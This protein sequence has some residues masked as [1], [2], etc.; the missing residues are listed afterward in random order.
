MILSQPAGPTC[1]HVARRAFAGAWAVLILAL[2]LALPQPLAAQQSGTALN[3]GG[4]RQ[5]DRS[6]PVEIEAAQLEVDQQTGLA[7]F[8]GDVVVTQGDMVMTAPRIEVEG[9]PGRGGDGIREV[10]GY[11]G[12]ALTAGDETAR[13]A[14]GVYDVATG[15]LVLTGDVVLTQGS[16][17]L[18]G[19]RLVADLNT[20]TGVME[21]RVRTVFT[22]GAART[23][24]Q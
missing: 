12:V 1:P 14:E 11:G 7:V 5:T 2:M 17:T 23:G 10:R 20:G 4:L 13:A 9:D 19:A 15:G 6:A 3:L 21:G 18:Q 22:P 8:T 24:A 16:S